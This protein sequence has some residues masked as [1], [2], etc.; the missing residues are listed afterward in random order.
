MVSFTRTCKYQKSP[1]IKRFTS[2]KCSTQVQLTYS[3]LEQSLRRHHLT[4]ATR[5]LLENDSRTTVSVCSLL[6]TLYSHTF[7]ILALMLFL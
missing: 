6:Y 7:Y 3:N 5:L 4:R 1:K 2:N